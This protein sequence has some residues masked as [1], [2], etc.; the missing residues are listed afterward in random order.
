MADGFY[1]SRRSASELRVNS[2]LAY[3]GGVLMKTIIAIR[4]LDEFAIEWINQQAK[5]QGVI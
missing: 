1:D 3:N 5:L 4:K 2:P